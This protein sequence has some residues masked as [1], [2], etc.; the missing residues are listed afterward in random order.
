VREKRHLL[1]WVHYKAVPTVT[2]A[3]ERANLNQWLRPPLSKVPSR[4]CVFAPH[5]RTETDPVS[6]TLCF[7]LSIISDHG[8]SPKTSNSEHSHRCQ[9]WVY[10]MSWWISIRNNDTKSIYALFFT[11]SNLFP[12]FPATEVLRNRGNSVDTA[13]G[14]GLN[15]LGSIPGSERFFASPQRQD[16]P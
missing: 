4:I 1:C 2:D 8:Q 12:G 10:V 11:A 5:L 16:R 7:L 6:R 3:L 13:T 15:G 14:Y 9:A